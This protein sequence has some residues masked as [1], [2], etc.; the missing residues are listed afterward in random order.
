V[1]PLLFKI[2]SNEMKK[3]FLA[4]IVMCGMAAA[5]VSCKPELKNV[6]AQV[7]SLDVVSDTLQSMLVSVD[8]QNRQVD[9]TRARIQNGIA[10]QGDSVI[11]DY[12]DGDN[13]KMIAV[14]C[15][16]LP[17][18]AQFFEP[19]DTLITKNPNDSIQ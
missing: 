1:L 9:M 11:L 17:R 6:R 7:L 19:C 12:I 3:A 14:I 16:L 5:F 2:E 13:G 15:T 10:I 8:G 18:P 4:L